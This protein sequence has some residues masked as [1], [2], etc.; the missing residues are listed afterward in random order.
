MFI[1]RAIRQDDLDALVALARKVGSGMTTLKPDPQALGARIEL[2]V[3][4]FAGEAP[5]SDR[6][7]VFVLEDQD[8]GAVA[9]V[10]ALKAA[11]GLDE[12]FYNFRLGRLVHSSRELG[13]YADK[14]TLYLTNDYTGCAELCTLFLDPAFRG[15]ENGRLLSKARLMFAANGL[16]LLPET[17][18]AELRGFQ[19]EDG[20]SPFWESLGRHFFRMDFAQADDISS[21]GP[22][23]FIAE[24]MP[25]Y[26]VYTDFLT[27]EARA[28]IGVVHRGTVPARR[29]LEQEGF[30][31][32]GYV[33]IFDAGPVLLAHT[34]RL[35]I[36]RESELAIVRL[37]GRDAADPE[38][39]AVPL[40]VANTLGPDFRVIVA[41][42]AIRYGRVD[43]TSRQLDALQLSEGDPVR[44]ATLNPGDHL[45]A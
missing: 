36:V 15:G 19:R 12:P 37:A 40:M 14:R 8:T 35:R 16:E 42:G 10:S 43:L 30:W 17:I 1:F 7:F 32:D 11:V 41:T 25:R 21:L 38:A 18:I 28:A 23:S 4:S 9:G 13:I 39:R 5:A 44:V 3:R 6:D 45:H 34:R 27:D 2:A 20:T 24:L 26:P 22:K 31:Y 29:L 33:D